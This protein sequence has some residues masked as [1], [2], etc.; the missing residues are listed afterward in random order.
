[1]EKALTSPIVS[2]CIPTYR[3]VDYLR[4]TLLS[5][6]EQ[7]FDD[8][9]LI[10]SDDTTDDT[11]KQLVSSFGFDDRLRY[12]HNPTA[13]GS[14]ENW[15][16]AV[17]HAEGKYIK[18]LHHDDRF[19]TPW[20][21]RHFVRLLDENAEADFAFSASSAFNISRGHSRDHSPKEEQ[22]AHFLV[23]PEKLLLNNLIGAPSATIYKNGLELEYDCALKW[24]VD[25]DFYIR[26]L[27]KNS[28]F[29]Y[30]PVVLIATATNASHQVTE[31]CKNNAAV[32][33]SEYMYLYEKLSLKPHDH[34]WVA[35]VWF[36]LFEKY[37]VY[38]E[39]DLRRN[40]IRV[41]NEQGLLQP[42]FDDYQRKFLIRTPQRIYAHLPESLKNVTRTIIGR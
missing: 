17:R 39:A 4:E 6:Q 26:I 32:E 14:P 35:D 24:L 27:R 15:N 12:Y 38:S 30:S 16:A 42:F 2:I 41:D 31:L 5:I 11:V 40:G 8:Y 34:S 36:R 18:L 1:L 7:D 10:I 37:R 19:A 23:I 9:E 28:S 3:Q 13:L 29:V 33:I 25:I 21:L 22:I 20:A